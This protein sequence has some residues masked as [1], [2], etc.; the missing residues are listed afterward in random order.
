MRQTRL[1]TLALVAAFAISGLATA[2]AFGASLVNKNNEALV[3]NGFKLT[4]AAKTFVLETRAGNKI[5]CT[6][7]AE[8]GAATNK[9][10]TTTTGKMQAK[11]EGC[12][13]FGLKCSSAGQGEGIIVANVNLTVENINLVVPKE[14]TVKNTLP[15]A[16]EIKCGGATETIIVTGS[17]LT[18]SVTPL[19]TLKTA[20][21]INA[22]QTKGV[23]EPL[24]SV[25]GEFS[26]EAEGKG[27]KPFAKEKAGEGA[28]AETGLEEEVKFVE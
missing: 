24:K 18:Q 22:K 13:S 11:F 16:L 7:L 14:V 23:Q 17:F 19:G 27:L 10:E 1:L 2:A 26:L 6:K 4:S 3:K 5:E 25:G 20:F 28:S 12:N 15:A 8:T 9:A 21:A